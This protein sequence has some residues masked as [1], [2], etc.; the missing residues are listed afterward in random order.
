M[1]M[2]MMMKMIAFLNFMDFSQMIMCVRDAD[3]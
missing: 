2:V 1:M 3:Q